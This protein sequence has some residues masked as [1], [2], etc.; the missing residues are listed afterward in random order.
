MSHFRPLA[1]ILAFVVIGQAIVIAG[2]LATE[3]S[4]PS[5]VSQQQLD[6]CLA[7]WKKTIV[8]WNASTAHLNAILEAK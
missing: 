7:G 2:L 4:R 6:Q 8:D 5:S 1:R 3:D